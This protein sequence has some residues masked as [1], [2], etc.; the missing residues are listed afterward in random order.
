MSFRRLNTTTCT[1]RRMVCFGWPFFCRTANRARL[2]SS[3]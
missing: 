1:K 3:T 2:T